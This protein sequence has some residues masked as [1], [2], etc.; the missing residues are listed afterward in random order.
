M[1]NKP[2]YAYDCGLPNGIPFYSVNS[3]CTFETECLGTDKYI[4]WDEMASSRKIHLFLDKIKA[5]GIADKNLYIRF[6]TGAEVE[7]G[8]LDDIL[9]HSDYITGISIVVH[10]DDKKAIEQIDKLLSEIEKDFI[11]VARCNHAW[12]LMWEHS[13]FK[14]TNTDDYFAKG[15]S[16]TYINKRLVDSYHIKP[17]QNTFDFDYDGDSDYIINS[18]VLLYRYIPY[19]VKSSVKDFYEQ[20][21]RKFEKCLKK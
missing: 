4:V 18:D 6:D 14:I 13:I 16:L 1:Y 11:L 5:V 2:S 10:C 8:I 7:N 12:H 15:V 3:L 21:K 9:S 20:T 19:V 17:N